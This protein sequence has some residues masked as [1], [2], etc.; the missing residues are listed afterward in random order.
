MSSV[1][2]SVVSQAP[3]DLKKDSAP[4][5]AELPHK[6]IGYLLAAL[7]SVGPFTIDTY[8]PSFIEISEK[9][10]TS[11][12][13]VQQTIT[14]YL[15]GFG[16]MSL[17]HG[18]ISDIFGRK[19]I[20]IIG[21]FIYLL[22]AIGCAF[23]QSI[24]QLII[25]RIIQGL[26]AGSGVIIARAIVRDIYSGARAQK[27][28]SQ[29]SMLFAIAPAIAPIIGGFIQIHF[30]W[31]FQFVFLATFAGV[32]IILTLKFLPETL[33]K[34]CRQPFKFITLLQGYLEIFS[35]YRF[36]FLTL[37]ITFLFSG[38]FMTVLSAPHILIKTLGLRE[39]QF[40]IFFV[41]FTLGMMFGSFISGRVAQYWSHAKILKVAFILMISSA[42]MSATYHTF[43]P[44]ALPWTI[45]FLP[46]YTIG[47][48]MAMPS[49]TLLIFDLF[50]S[51]RGMI[52]SCQSFIQIMGSSFFAGIL[53]PLLWD[54][55]LNLTLAMLCLC[56]VSLSF[57]ILLSKRK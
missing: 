12:A 30:G 16:L 5:P 27:L 51:R 2:P 25:F 6:A 44:P 47:M 54:K 26:S 56:V 52:S 15:I 24:E 9:L 32:L 13:M 31:R 36:W 34:N 33:P 7:T 8:L 41:P 1:S 14:A 17:W 29:M 43:Y 38:F 48:S 4:P 42:L 35:N 19:K 55:V 28:M 53:A 23:A 40:Y 50:P 46:I 49:I 18:A 10:N 39:N 21:M 20:I 37:S 3:A 22:A 45:S 11:T 57:L